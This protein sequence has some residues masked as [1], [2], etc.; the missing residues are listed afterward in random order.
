M[1]AA[2]MIPGIVQKMSHAQRWEVL[3]MP[4]PTAKVKKMLMI[5]EGVLSSAE[6]GGEKP[7]PLIRVAE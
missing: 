3:R 1:S 4:I 6:C 5:P 2:P 7:N